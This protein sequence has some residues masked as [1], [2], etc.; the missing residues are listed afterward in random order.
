MG[1]GMDVAPKLTTC[2]RHYGLCVSQKHADWKHDSDNTVTDKYH[3]R[4]IIPD[5]LVWLIRKGDVILPD[6]PIVST[7]VITCKF[8]KEALKTGGT[9]RITFVATD[10]EPP[11]SNLSKLPR[12]TVYL[13]FHASIV[14]S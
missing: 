14:N 6:K 2:P 8:T 3:G 11:P 10:E 12:G 9:V 7:F 5:Q 13:F 1:I 4:Q